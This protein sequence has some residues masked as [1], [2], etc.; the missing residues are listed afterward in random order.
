M[1]TKRFADFIANSP[2]NNGPEFTAG[3][4]NNSGMNSTVKTTGGGVQLIGQMTVANG[5][6]FNMNTLAD[7]ILTLQ[8]GNNFQITNIVVTN[9]SIPVDSLDTI[10]MT[11]YTGTFIPGEYINGSISGN[12][13][14]CYTVNGNTIEVSND[15]GLQEFVVSDVLTGLISGAQATVSVVT[16][17]TNNAQSMAFYSGPTRTGFNYFNWSITNILITPNSYAD[18]INNTAVS[19]NINSLLYPKKIYVSILQAKGAP[20]TVDIYVYGTPIN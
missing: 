12:S 18:R 7:Q 17:A 6:P 16:H 8:N 9:P 1:N 15:A 19:V 5:N 20:C 4:I 14:F 2:E 3:I 13:G 10:T 11:G